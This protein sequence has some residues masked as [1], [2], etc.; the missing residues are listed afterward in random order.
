M[1]EPQRPHSGSVFS[2]QCGVSVTFFDSLGRGPECWVQ[3]LPSSLTFAKPYFMISG[4]SPFF[5][6]PQFPTLR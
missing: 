1:L 3:D 4:K 5:S 2:P 6:G